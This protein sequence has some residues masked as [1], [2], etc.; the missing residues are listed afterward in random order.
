MKVADSLGGRGI[1]RIRLN[2]WVNYSLYPKGDM[3]NLEFNIKRSF[4][5]NDPVQPATYGK[6]VTGLV[7]SDTVFRIT[8][9]TTKWNHY[10]A[11]DEFGYATIK[12]FI[13]MRLGETYL[14]LTGRS[15]GETGQ[16]SG[17]GYQYQ[18]L[19]NTRQSPAGDRV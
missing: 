16:V 5:Y 19:T 10:I 3:R 17:C 8:P 9:Y 12:D 6:K 13:M 18:C 14:L 1:G 15:P 7:G 4:F 2:N 11:T